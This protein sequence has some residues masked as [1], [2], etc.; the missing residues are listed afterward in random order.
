MNRFL[1]FLALGLA[2]PLAA[3]AAPK[4]PR[5]TAELQGF[6]AQN[7]VRCHGADGS[8][9]GPDGKRLN[10]MDFTDSRAMAQAKDA[11]LAKA[12]LKGRK[13]GLEMPAY[14]DQL[15]AEEAQ[16]LVSEVLRKAQKGKPIGP[17]PAGR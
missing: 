13:F 10:G 7:C 17:Q 16:A 9:V 14:K 1:P 8:A 15:S 2:L 4:A 3:Q 12:I 6:Y 11:S 5:S